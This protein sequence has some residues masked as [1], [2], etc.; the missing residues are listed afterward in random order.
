MAAEIIGDQIYFNGISRM[1][2]TVDS[3]IF[4]RRKVMP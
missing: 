4:T 3:G 2:Q 1:G